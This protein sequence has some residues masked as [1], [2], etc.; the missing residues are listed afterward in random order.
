MSTKDLRLIERRIENLQE[1]IG[2][3][4]KERIRDDETI[5]D[6]TKL[7]CILISGFLE[8]SVVDYIKT[9]STT[10]S[11]PVIQNYISKQ[12]VG[13]T[14]LRIDKIEKLLGQFDSNWEIRL[15][16][17]DRYDDFETAINYVIGNRNTIAHGGSSGVTAKDLGTSYDTI[18]QFL[19]EI[20]SFFA[21]HV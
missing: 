21:V 12:L 3:L 7:L 15:K 4:N 5:S 18:K 8:K 20:K 17:L 2:S 11:N 1:R 9:Y 16:E 10:R 6:L 13:T 14:N 19:A